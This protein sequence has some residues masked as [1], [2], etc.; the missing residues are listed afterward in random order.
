MAS[1]WEICRSR[2]RVLCAAGLGL[3]R[4]WD[5]LRLIA[6]KSRKRAVRGA[7]PASRR[8]KGARLHVHVSP[9]PMHSECAARGGLPKWGAVEAHDARRAVWCVPS[10][11]WRARGTAPA[12]PGEHEHTCLE[13]PG[14]RCGATKVVTAAVVPWRCPDGAQAARA[15]SL[16]VQAHLVLGRRLGRGEPAGAVAGGVSM[17]WRCSHGAARSGATQQRFSEKVR[18]WRRA[19]AGILVRA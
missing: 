11:A 9:P 14:V 2:S 4:V 19:R 16:F 18:F 3:D 6:A 12:H 1:S 10:A 17:V 8:C 15:V 13:L 5:G 7:R